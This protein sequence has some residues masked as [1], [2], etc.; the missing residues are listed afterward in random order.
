[1]SG[2]RVLGSATGPHRA[3]GADQA[4]PE[5]CGLPRRR[6][7]RAVRRRLPAAAVR[8]GGQSSPSTA[9]GSRRT[10]PTSS[11]SSSATPGGRSACWCS[12]A[13]S[14]AG[15]SPAWCCARWIG[16]RMPHGGPATVTRPPGLARRAPRRADRPRRHLRRDARSRAAHDRRGAPFRRQRLARAAH[17]ARDH[18]HHGRGR[19]RPIRT[20]ATS[21]SSCS[22]SVR[23][24]T[25]DRLHRGAARAGES[26]A[27]RQRSRCQ[28][29]TWRR[30]RRRQS[31]SCERMLRPAASVW[32]RRSDRGGDRQPAAAGA[33]DGE[34]RGKR[35][36]A[37]HRGRWVRV[38]PCHRRRHSQ[39]RTAASVLPADIVVTLIEPF[40]RGAGRGRTAGGHD[41]AGLGLAIVASIVRAHRDA[42]VDALPGGGLQVRVTLPR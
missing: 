23:P 2:C 35:D 19:C 1:M 11:R 40:V 3:V 27:R 41:G 26:R 13:S 42:S 25:G 16:S 28:R 38:S 32:T 30:W 9:A 33:A 6:R 7:H 36:R 4:H 22:G 21:T 17:A 29:S 12:S 18:P 39:W 5:L 20:G 37:Q 14:A 24:T 31:T 34:S 10:A 8:A 15:C